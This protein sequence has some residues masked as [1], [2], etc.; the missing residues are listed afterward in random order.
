MNPNALLSQLS[1]AIEP[2]AISIWPIA[3]IWWLI[4]IVTCA[5]IVIITYLAVSKLQKYATQR[6]YTKML[7]KVMS[8]S[9]SSQHKVFLFA[10]F[11]K[12][13]AIKSYGR[14]TVA[15]LSGKH[16][17]AFLDQTIKG[18]RFSEGAGVHLCTNLYNPHF[19]FTHTHTQ[20]IFDL[21]TYWIKHHK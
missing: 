9:Y 7:A 10:N 13:Y 4:I 15:G 16:W 2:H 6:K 5:T 19:T 21:L 3:P 8:S 12:R 14:K 1:P 11:L 20:Q 18:N 17:A